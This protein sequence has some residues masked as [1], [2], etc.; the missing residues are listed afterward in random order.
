MV[1]CFFF[2]NFKRGQKRLKA[3][4]LRH[5][6]LSYNQN[7]LKILETISVSLLENDKFI[8]VNSATFEDSY[9]VLP[10]PDTTRTYPAEVYVTPAQVTSVMLPTVLFV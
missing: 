7:S 8:N 9:V 3:V 4:L 5:I 6:E 10:K 1:T 2:E